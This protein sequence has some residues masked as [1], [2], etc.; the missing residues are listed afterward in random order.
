LKGRVH[1]RLF[2]I[3]QQDNVKDVETAKAVS[4][5][6][7][8]LENLDFGQVDP[9]FAPTKSGW[10]GSKQLDVKRW[11]AHAIGSIIALKR[12]KFKV[13]D[14]EKLV[15]EA[16]G[17]GWDTVHQWRKEWEKTDIP[18]LKEI[19]DGYRKVAPPVAG[20]PKAT[21]DHMLDTLKEKGQRYK[22]ALGKTDKKTK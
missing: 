3:E 17:V 15:A 1:L 22:M 9:I 10:H 13:L 21:P 11:M 19:I 12:L 7:T 4:S 5:A 8:A 20:G 18:T 6:I 14:A 16:Y 2:L